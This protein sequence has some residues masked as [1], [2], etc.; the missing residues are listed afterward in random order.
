MIM[1]MIVIANNNNRCDMNIYD[2]DNINY[3]NYMTIII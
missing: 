1:M 2:D 3:D